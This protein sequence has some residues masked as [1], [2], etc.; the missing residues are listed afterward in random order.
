MHYI[1]FLVFLSPVGYVCSPGSVGLSGC[2]RNTS[3]RFEC[4]SCKNS[5][6]CSLYEHC[7]S[8]CLHPDKQP[9]LRSILRRSTANYHPLFSSL[10]DQFELCL[11][12]C[13]TSSQ[14]H[15]CMY[16]SNIR[17]LTAYP[18]PLSLTEC[19]TREHIPRPWIEILLWTRHFKLIT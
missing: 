14:V 19:T 6:C 5:D 11:T 3:P 18:L 7:V 12:K 15:V 1:R 16:P 13:R 4:S 2:C 8:C 10:K 17:P 9:L